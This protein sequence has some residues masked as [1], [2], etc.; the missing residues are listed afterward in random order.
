MGDATWI[1]T[2]QD[3]K[4]ARDIIVARAELAGMD[5][6]DSGVEEFLNDQVEVQAAMAAQCRFMQNVLHREHFD[7]AGEVDRV[8][9]S[10]NIQE[11]E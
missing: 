11:Q 2:E 6:L 5:T 1:T 8:I 10:F 9:K 3:R 4:Q 7:T